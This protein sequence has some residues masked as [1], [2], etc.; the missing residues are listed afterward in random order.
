MVLSFL[1]F[2]T[3]VIPSGNLGLGKTTAAARASAAHSYQCVCILVRLNNGVVARVGDFLLMCAY[4]LM[5][6]ITHGGCTN[7]VTVCTER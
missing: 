4:M 5:H 3:S 2:S 6:A 7:T 1:S